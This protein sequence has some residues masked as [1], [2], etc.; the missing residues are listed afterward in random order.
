M[1]AL[2]NSSMDGVPPA[3]TVRSA[4]AGT[5]SC[6]RN[7]CER[8]EVRLTYASERVWKQGKCGRP[9]AQL[10]PRARQ[11]VAGDC[12]VAWWRVVRCHSGCQ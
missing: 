9:H 11:I 8:E 4:C 12:I 10:G 1:L 2:V 6:T 7:E 5:Q 3:H